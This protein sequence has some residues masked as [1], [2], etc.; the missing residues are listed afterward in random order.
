MI[1]NLDIDFNFKK[2]NV[3]ELFF[4]LSENPEGFNDTVK[5][6]GC[7]GDIMVEENLHYCVHVRGKNERH[8][9]SQRNIVENLR[10]G[11]A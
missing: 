11:G 9:C 5:Q 2:N 8:A 7:G 4:N 3:D 6:N 1:D 10:T